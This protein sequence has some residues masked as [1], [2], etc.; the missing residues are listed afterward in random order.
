MSAVH[1]DRCR[2]A[3]APPYQVR[4]RDSERVLASGVLSPAAPHA[5]PEST[6]SHQTCDTAPTT[7]YPQSLQ[8]GMY[9]RVAVGSP[10]TSMDLADLLGQAR[11][12]GGSREGGLPFQS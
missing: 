9:S 7:A 3:E 1:R 10:A 2:S 6:L 5:A 12:L 11:V 4:S 8:F